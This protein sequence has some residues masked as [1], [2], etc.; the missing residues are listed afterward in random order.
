MNLRTGKAQIEKA[1]Q[2]IRVRRS[3]GSMGHTVTSEFSRN[4]Y[5]ACSIDNVYVVTRE[6]NERTNTKILTLLRKS[7]HGAPAPDANANIAA[8][9][10]KSALCETR[11]LMDYRCSVT[12]NFTA[13]LFVLQQGGDGSQASPPFKSFARF[14][15]IEVGT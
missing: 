2:D 4:R 9:S 7:S 3:S 6:R 8:K 11:G 12:L 13:T 14:A 1:R 10:T 5:Q 15:L